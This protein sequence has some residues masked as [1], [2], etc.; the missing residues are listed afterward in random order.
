MATETDVGVVPDELDV[1]DV[2]VEVAVVPVVLVV[3]ALPN[4][5]S[6]FALTVK[7]VA[8]PTPLSGFCSSRGDWWAVPALS[9]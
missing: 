9:T 1:E 5:P 7:V 4:A 2:S 8:T 3:L 6:V